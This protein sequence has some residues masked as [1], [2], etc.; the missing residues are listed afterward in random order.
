MNTSAGRVALVSPESPQAWIEDYGSG[1]IADGVGHVELDPLFLE[2]VTI[3][4]DHPMKVFVQLTSP[5]P[6]VVYVRKLRTGFN[7]I[8]SDGGKAE[9][10][11]DYKVV[12]TWRGQE[13]FRFEA[14]DAP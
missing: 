10:S 11:F 2:C 8:A 6:H 12:A 1:W 9:A 4:D 14:V 7:V 3:D 13:R 5:F